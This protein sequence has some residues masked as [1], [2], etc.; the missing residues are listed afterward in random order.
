MIPENVLTH[1]E[2][3]VVILTDGGEYIEARTQQK[4]EDYA[5]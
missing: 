1:R 2:G 3:H 5:S 4:P